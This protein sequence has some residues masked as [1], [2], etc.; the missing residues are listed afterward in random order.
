MI[1]A[2]LIKQVDTADDRGLENYIMSGLCE[3][4]TGSAPAL[5]A[6]G[7]AVE[8]GNNA[9]DFFDVEG[10]TVGVMERLM[11]IAFERS[12]RFE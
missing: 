7:R 11:L 3:M 10:V 8:E 6:S 4:S 12:W 2:C 1:T 5:E 9:V